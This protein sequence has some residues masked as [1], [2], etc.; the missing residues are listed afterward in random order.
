MLVEIYQ[1]LSLDA[2]EHAYQQAVRLLAVWSPLLRSEIKQPQ[3]ISAN[4]Q[5]GS[6]NQGH[7]TAR[8]GVGIALYVLTPEM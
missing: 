7:R 6:G 8:G 1:H 4:Y 2:V 5:D 3:T